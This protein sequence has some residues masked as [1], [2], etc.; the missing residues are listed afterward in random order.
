[1]EK[2]DRESPFCS[3]SSCQSGNRWDSTDEIMLHGD[4]SPDLTWWSSGTEIFDN[5][6]HGTQSNL[7]N[8]VKIFDRDQ[9]IWAVE[10][11]PRGTNPSKKLQCNVDL[12]RGEGSERRFSINFFHRA[13]SDLFN[14]AKIIDQDQEL[15]SVELFPRST[16]SSKTLH[17]SATLTRGERG[18]RRILISFHH[19]ARPDLSNGVRIIV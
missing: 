13:Q 1:M 5:F 10:L 6:F 19:G 8:G 3:L 16:A 7:F 4:S 2:I 9:E 12:T 17:C 11:P 14:G 18:E 15:R